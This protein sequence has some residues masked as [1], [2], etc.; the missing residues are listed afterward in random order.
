MTFWFP[1]GLFR[2]PATPLA[3]WPLPKIGE[4]E[5]AAEKQQEAEAVPVHVLAGA[6]SVRIAE[7]RLIVER[8]GE[9]AVERPVGNP[10]GGKLHRH[11]IVRCQAP[12]RIQ[13]ERRRRGAGEPASLRPDG[14]Q[15]AG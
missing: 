12:L 10:T 2:K 15:N 7:G 13:G 5:A 9:P 3:G 14:R 8:S 1:R 4:E 6:A 11:Q